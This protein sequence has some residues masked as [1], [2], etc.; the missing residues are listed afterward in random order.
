ML[1]SLSLR[2]YLRL[3]YLG[4]FNGLCY[5]FCFDWRWSSRLSVKAQQL[6]MNFCCIFWFTFLSLLIDLHPFLFHRNWLRTIILIRIN[7]STVTRVPITCWFVCYPITNCE[8]HRWLVGSLMLLLLHRFSQRLLL[9]QG[10]LFWFR[11]YDSL[12]FSVSFSLYLLSLFGRLD[13]NVQ[14]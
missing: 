9:F 7:I 8:N 12:S 1:C 2:L 6:I 5:L 10:R 13:Y 11:S 14:R 3:V 4:H